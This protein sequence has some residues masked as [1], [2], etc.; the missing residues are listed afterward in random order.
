MCNT[1][2]APFSGLVGSGLGESNQRFKWQSLSEGGCSHSLAFM[3]LLFS[4]KV[5]ARPSHLKANV[6]S[7]NSSR[8]FDDEY[9]RH[10]TFT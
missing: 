5:S 3:C 4:F 8:W 9:F 1:T 6:K 2:L 7:V 10:L